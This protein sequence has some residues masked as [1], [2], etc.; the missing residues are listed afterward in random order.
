MSRGQTSVEL[1]VISVVALVILGALV[2]FTAEQLRLVQEQKAVKQVELGLQKIAN[3][4]NSVYTQ[5]SGAV[6]TVLVSW[7]DGVDANR[8]RVSGHSLSTFVYSRSVYADT[9]PLVVGSL[10]TSS[11]TFLIPVKAFDGFVAVGDISL[12]AVPSFIFSSLNRDENAQHTFSIVNSGSDADV[13]FSLDW[14]HSL[15]DV[16]LSTFSSSLS[17]GSSVDVNVDVNAGSDAV[18]TYAGFIHVSGVFS[19]KTESLVLPLSVSVGLENN[20]PFVAYPDT[21]SISTYLS[22]SNTTSIQLCNTS[23]VALQS[24]SFT[25]STGNAGDWVQG[26][27]PIATLD[28]LSCTSVSITVAPSVDAGLGTY[29]GSIHISDGEGANTMSLPL[30]VTVQGMSGIF[31]WDWSTAVK[32]PTLISDFSLTNTGNVPVQIDKIKLR[33]W[34]DCDTDD[35]NLTSVRLNG[36]TVFS[37]VAKDGNWLDV[38]DFNLPILT[39]WTNNTISFSGDV[40][41]EN[42]TFIA[43]VQFD[44]GSVYT[45]AIYTDEC[46]DS[47]APGPISDL[48]VSMG[49]QAGQVVLGFTF[50]GDDGSDGTISE[51]EIRTSPTLITLSEFQNAESISYEGDIQPG[52]T[53]GTLTIDGMDPGIVTYF[54][55]RAVDEVSNRAVSQIKPG[56][57]FNNYSYSA[58]DFNFTNMVHSDKTTAALTGG[59]VNAF[60]VFAVALSPS[61]ASHS[62]RFFIQEDLNLSNGW[63]TQL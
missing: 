25:P 55:V 33:N 51:L 40:V 31:S 1:L 54:L 5:G 53:Y 9:I 20:S 47:V 14:N 7:P 28:A 24:V 13:T 42:E 34:L 44:D 58:G 39:T 15:V 23:N 17:G 41:D 43:D 52:G 22:D 49:S 62:L 56:K 18:G 45:S 21:V 12:H 29:E 50:P 26:I 35:S 32:S 37:G 11:G 57:P 4:V 19:S 30:S 27:S 46:T 36:N 16:N 2:G 10:P 6:R 8:T 3:A 48:T 59:D 63:A 38:A 61:A 60:T